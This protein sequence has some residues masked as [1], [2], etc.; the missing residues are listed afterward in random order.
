MSVYKII[1]GGIALSMFLGFVGML[2]MFVF[3][4]MAIVSLVK[5]NGKAKKQGMYTGISTV[6]FIAG[7]SIPSP[8]PQETVAEPQEE[9]KQD[10]PKQEETTK[11]ESTKVEPE[12]EKEEKPAKEEPKEEPELTLSQENA[13]R[14]AKS[15]LDYT[16]FS[17]SGLVKQLEF[18]EYSAEDAEFAVNHIEVDWNAQAV[19]AGKDYLDYSS[20]SRN[21]LIDQLKFDG[22]TTEQAT[23]AVDEIGL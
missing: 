18:E 22:F 2:G 9:V 1:T 7:L 15:Y 5:K 4:I 13:L 11:E 23:Y 3:G 6:L 8:E 19:Q 20:F 21:G 10:E 14:S 12:E 17:K 16:A